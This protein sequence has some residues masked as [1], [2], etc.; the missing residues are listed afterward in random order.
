MS[1][2][3]QNWYNLQSTRRYPLDDASTGEDDNGGNLRDSILVD[4]HIRAPADF[5]P[6]F[7]IQGLTISDTLIS[8]VIGAAT[9]L[10]ATENTTIC[11][12]TVLKPTAEYVNIPVMPI[13]AGVAGW[14]AF[15]A[16][17]TE[18]FVGRY[19][20][21]QQTLIAARCGRPYANLP[22]KSLGKYNLRTSLTNIVTITA[23]APITATYY[24]E[25]V[26][27]KY[28][29]L[30]GETNS[31]P[32]KAIVFS[33]AAPTAD[34]N[35]YS[36]FL[37]PCSDRPES[38]TCD[39]TPIETINGVAPDC[40]TGNINVVVG[41]GISARPFVDCGGTD[42]TTPLGLEAACDDKPPG[43]QKSRDICCPDEVDGTS[44]YCW[45][46]ETATEATTL[47]L[48]AP[49]SILPVSLSL[50]PADTDIFF[51]RIG[52]FS[53]RGGYYAALNDNGTNIATYEST[54]SDWLVNTTVSAV[55]TFQDTEITA[56]GVVLNCAR[57]FLS[58]TPV[59]TYFA[60]VINPNE[61]KLQIV[62]HTGSVLVLEQEA[63][64]LP[65]AD[66]WRVSFSAQQNDELVELVARVEDAETSAFVTELHTH[67][68]TYEIVNGKHGIISVNAGA[69]FSSFNITEKAITA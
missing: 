57:S 11:A 37:G 50:P 19:S 38:G 14:I 53:E 62:R 43:Q 69:L 17:I 9:S 23:A 33:G 8:V 16:G 44:E 58:Q 31:Q 55:L 35:P 30:T 49:P 36:Y 41:G 45:P 7:Y 6:Y 65:A 51:T 54:P 27:P 46:E 28:N 13:Q 68:N 56:A 12:A 40:A 34:F 25:Y 52:E 26:V 24:D 47:P 67:V 2:R 22:I 15:G 63:L 48:T 61:K 64:E 39:K 18:P 59:N 4:C 66:K 32:V 20:T 3:N 29:P 21:A 10:A 60:A 1:V 5:G 42:L